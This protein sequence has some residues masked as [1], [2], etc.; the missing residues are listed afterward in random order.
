MTTARV[1]KVVAVRVDGAALALIVSPAILLELGL[2]LTNVAV[3]GDNCVSDCD[4]KSQ[5]DPGFGAKWAER[6]KCPLNVCC[7]KHGYCGV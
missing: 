6:E 5:C 3:C 4:R 7:S 1:R 2:P